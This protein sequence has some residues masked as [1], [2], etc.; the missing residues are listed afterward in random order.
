[1]LALPEEPFPAFYLVAASRILPSDRVLVFGYHVL[2]H[3]V[4]LAR[5]GV[6]TAL[7]LYAGQPYRP[8][9]AAD[10]VWFVGVADIEIEV[11][12]LLGSVGM[13]RLIAVELAGGGEDGQA[14]K[15]FATL[16]RHGFNRVSA[17]RPGKN[18]IVAA[19]KSAPSGRRRPGITDACGSDRPST[20]TQASRRSRADRY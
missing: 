14:R 7:G 9:E 1:M 8:R 20:P 2:D 19:W 11:A 5:C 4:G 10:V 12:R 15:L 3:L 6:E 16:G 13:P 18:L 17:S